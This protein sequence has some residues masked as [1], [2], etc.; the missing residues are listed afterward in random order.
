MTFKDKLLHRLGRQDI[1]AVALSRKSGIPVKTIHA[2]IQGRSEPGMRNLILLTRTLG[3][4]A[5]DLFPD[6][7]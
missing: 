3:C 4:K 5:E 2:W 1:T 7:V 6:N